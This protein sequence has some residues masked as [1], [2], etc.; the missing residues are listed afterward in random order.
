MSSPR[1]VVAS[2]VAPNHLRPTV[3]SITVGVNWLFSF[4]ISKITPIMLNSI[5]FGT[6]L[7]FGF[8]CLIMAVWTYICLPETSG[9]ALEDIKYLFENDVILR[10]LQDAPGGRF[11]LR[12]KRVPSVEELKRE[13]EVLVEG[14]GRSE[15]AGGRSSLDTDSA[16]APPFV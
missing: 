8:C 7:L 3:L 6:F 2:E 15:E 12:G 14:A 1:W 16:K 13:H 9:Y 10:S 4:T 5:K 11:F